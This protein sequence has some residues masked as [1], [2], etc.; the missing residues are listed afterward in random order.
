M[1]FIEQHQY[2]APPAAV[3]SMLS[4]RGFRE[5][6]CRA[7][8]A[9]QWDVDVSTDEGGGTIRVRRVIPARVSDAV[10]RFVGET[11]TIVQTEQW[12]PATPD[13]ARTADLHLE[14][15][16]QPAAMTGAHSLAA[17]GGGTAFEVAGDLK[18]SIPLLGGKI[19]KEIAKAV[20]AG[21][22]EEHKLG[23]RYLS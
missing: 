7:T 19:E 13:G 18:V 10:K 2:D 6:V 8:G 21:L 16:G 23:V 12:G 5:E 20:S 4:D 9:R 15:E 1:K 22:A 3:W 14:V 17:Q 11:V